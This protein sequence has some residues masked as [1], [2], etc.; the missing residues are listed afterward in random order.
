VA[1][2]FDVVLGQR[3]CREFLPDPVPD[4]DLERMLDAATHA[5]SAENRQP[6]VFVVVTDPARRG[7]I[8]D[9]MAQAWAAA[10]AQDAE[11]ALGA[12]L[13]RDVDRGMHGGF[14]TAP[15][16]V[17]VAVDRERTGLGSP[18][19]SIWP[20]VQNLLLAANALG[21]GSALTNLA[22]YA[23]DLAGLLELPE[24]VTPMAVVPIGRPARPLGR[25]RRRP[26]AEVTYRDAFGRRS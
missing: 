16:L 4:A 10:G 9:A 2:F 20:A 19:S 14:A 12:S 11:R 26:A 6:W 5:P 22:V 25:A 18:A 3:A 17:V 8:T 15:V 24:T 13:A 1:D 23:A 21:Y 7:A